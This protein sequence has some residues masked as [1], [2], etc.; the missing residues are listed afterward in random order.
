MTQLLPELWLP[1]IRT[2]PKRAMARVA[3]GFTA[4]LA[5]PDFWAA[6]GAHRFFEYFRAR[7]PPQYLCNITTSMSPVWSALDPKDMDGV[8]ET[9]RQR[10][11]IGRSRHLF[12]MRL[13]NDPGA[14]SVGFSYTEVDASR[15]NR[16]AVIEVS[17]PEMSSSKD[18]LAYAVE[19]IRIGP[20]HSLVGG[21]AFRYDRAHE[22][23]AFHQ[24]YAWASRYLAIDIQKSEEMAWKTPSSL[25]GVNWLTYIG[26]EVARRNELDLAA[27]CETRW[28][29]DIQDG[30]VDD[31]AM[32]M[33]GPEP[34]QGDLNRLRLPEPYI[35]VAHRLAPYFADAPPDF[36]GPFHSQDHSSLWFRRLIEPEPWAERKID[37]DL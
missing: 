22:G 18:L 27:L 20:V 34:V 1:T 17:F 12:N 4:Y 32:F 35:E 36:W 14:E 16:S 6:E 25:P 19:L 11:V 13:Q 2:D 30:F 9:L 24:I 28:T 26:P 29:T 31:G 21:L 23:P 8:A 15:A 5:D 10:A 37:L 33:A 7:I 3:M